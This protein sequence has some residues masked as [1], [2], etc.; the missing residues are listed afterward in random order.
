MAKLLLAD[1]DLRSDN[2]RSFSKVK[3]TPVKQPAVKCWESVRMNQSYESE[4][5]DLP[6]T[7]DVESSLASA[8]VERGKKQK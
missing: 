3:T 2:I 1:I 7:I 6:I 5:N 8:F 4:T